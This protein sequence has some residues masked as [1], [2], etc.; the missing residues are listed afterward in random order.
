MKKMKEMENY[1]VYQN[2]P[3]PFRSGMKLSV[4]AGLGLT[5]FFVFLTSIVVFA[6]LGFLLPPI[7][8]GGSFSPFL[9]RL[10]VVIPILIVFL[11]MVGK[12]PESKHPIM[13][14]IVL[15]WR[16]RQKREYKQKIMV[17]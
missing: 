8:V 12:E 7:P 14:A 2:H 10:Y 6:G 9:G 17:G 1:S 16:F 15:R 3:L 13:R 4:I 11:F 5:E